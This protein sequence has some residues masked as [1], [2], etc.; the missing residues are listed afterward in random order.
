[1]VKLDLPEPETPVTQAEGAERDRGGDVLEV[2]GGGA[3]EGE[4][5]ARALA[6]L[7]RDRDRAAAAEIIG[8]QAGLACEHLVELP[9]QTTSPPWTPAPGPMSMT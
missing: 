1:M 5:L 9:W 8:G 7:G 6:A 2:V 3:G 4:L